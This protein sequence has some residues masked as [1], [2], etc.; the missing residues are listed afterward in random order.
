MAH[1]AYLDSDNIV[2]Q[3][4]VGKD[5]GDDGVDWEQYYGAV[6]CS[7]NTSGGEHLH[8][9]TPFRYNMAAIGSR[10]DPNFGPDGAFIPRQPF[11]S[12]VL[13][14]QTALWEAPIPR[15]EG[16]G[17]WDWDEESLSWVELPP[18]LLTSSKV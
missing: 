2:T 7:Y 13:N 14:S 15:P 8:G 4:I 17:R 10:F 18:A 9:G 6:R 5:E 12:W 3:V 16:T 11:P 1:Y